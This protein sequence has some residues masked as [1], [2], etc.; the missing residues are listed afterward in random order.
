[1]NFLLVTQML[2]N[3]TLD[4]KPPFVLTILSYTEYFINNLKEF[5]Y[6]LMVIFGSS[7][8]WIY[9]IQ[10]KHRKFPFVF[11]FFVLGILWGYVALGYTEVENISSYEMPNIYRL[12]F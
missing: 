2:F 12:F 4:S 11:V 6:S 9:L 3:L 8:V 5:P 1:M 10:T 7:L